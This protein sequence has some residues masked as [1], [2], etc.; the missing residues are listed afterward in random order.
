MTWLDLSY[1]RLLRLEDAV[2][3]TL[4]QLNY[5][6]LS[7]NGELD[8]N[9]KAFV[10]L[11]N[12]LFELKLNNLSLTNIPEFPLGQLKR[13]S[14]AYNE[15][16]ELPPELAINLTQ[17]NYLDLKFNDFT[18]IPDLIKCLP[19]LH[20]LSISGNPI[21]VLLN[22]SFEGISEELQELEL[23][24]L[25]LN[26]FDQGVLSHCRHLSRIVLSGYSFIKNFSI[27]KVTSQL[28][29]LKTIELHATEIFKQNTTNND[30]T[31][32]NVILNAIQ[33]TEQTNFDKE[34]DGKLPSKTKQIIF[35]GNSLRFIGEN[36]LNAVVSSDIEIIFQN[37][38]VSSLPV[39]LFKNLENMR[40]I[41]VTFNNI[42]STLSNL[43][44]PT[45]IH[46]FSRLLLRK[47]ELTGT[48]LVCDCGIG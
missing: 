34:L 39:N 1:N 3:S 38:G 11:E 8:I 28:Y 46:P 21:T 43:P 25:A 37:T 19:Q 44:N 35:T 14:L 17:L 40:Y 5:L 10:G 47:L 26:T 13:L 48:N 7:H 4:P 24:S 45:P 6:D 20:F 29:N 27:P 41:S 22:D 23:S 15:L 2:F 18:I 42:N 16:T 30:K 36:V 32:A 31:S 12:S 33:D 9:S